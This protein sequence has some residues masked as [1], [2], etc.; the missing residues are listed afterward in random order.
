[1][2]KSRNSLLQ[3][4]HCSHTSPLH[5]QVHERINTHLSPSIFLAAASLLHAFPTSTIRSLTHSFALSVPLSLYGLDWCAVM[6]L[7]SE[8]QRHEVGN[9]GRVYPQL[10]ISILLSTQ[11]LYILIFSEYLIFLTS[12]LLP[13]TYGPNFTSS[14]QSNLHSNINNTSTL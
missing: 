13:S 6:L 14:E 9:M 12:L 8:V 3:I 4:L 7:H 2:L 11:R 1:L 5:R 10:S